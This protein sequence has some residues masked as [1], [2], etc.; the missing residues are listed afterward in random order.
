MSP[1]PDGHRQSP[2]LASAPV[3]WT[4]SNGTSSSVSMDSNPE[5]SPSC[6]TSSFLI[7]LNKSLAFFTLFLVSSFSS[8]SSS[9]SLTLVVLFAFFFPL[10]L[11][12]SSSSS[13]FC[14]FAN[15]FSDSDAIFFPNNFAFNAAAA[16]TFASAS[17]PMGFTSAN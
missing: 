16:E 11:I 9:S 12:S 8:S 1:Q 17:L 15:A 13:S 3:A 2:G 6:L 14:S 4:N 5:S 10:L 7:S